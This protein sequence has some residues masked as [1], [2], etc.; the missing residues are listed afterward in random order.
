MN[1]DQMMDALFSAPT[2]A[3]EVVPLDRAT[4]EAILTELEASDPNRGIV[5]GLRLKLS[6]PKVELWAIH[7]VGPGEVY[8]A[9]DRAHAERM[10]ADLDAC[11]QREKQRRIDEGKSL[12]HWFDWV[13]NIIPSPWEPDDHF[14]ELARQSLDEEQRLRDG[15]TKADGE[16]DELLAALQDL[17]TP[18]TERDPAKWHAARKTAHAVIAKVTAEEVALKARLK[19]LETVTA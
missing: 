9:L 14:E 12:E 10:V 1:T 16:R 15:W 5:V 17:M 4:V 18:S 19:A 6:A 8:P 11:C 7:T 2:P 3:N 13:T